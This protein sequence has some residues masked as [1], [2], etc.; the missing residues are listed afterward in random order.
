MIMK[1]KK[2]IVSVLIGMLAGQIFA[3]GDRPFTIINTLRVGYDDN[4]YRTTNDQE[5]SAYIRDIIDL[6]FRAALSDRTDLTFQSRFDYNSDKEQN[7]YPNLY[8]ILTHSAS[9]RLLLKLSNKFES[10]STTS[11]TR[12]GKYNY[13]INTLSFVPSYVLDSKNSLSTPVSYAIKRHEQIAEQLDYDTVSAGVTWKR[14]LVPQQTWAALSLSQKMIDYIN[15][16]SK[17]E[18][19]FASATVSHTFNPTLQG[20][21]GAG[22]TYNQSDFSIQLPGGSSRTITSDGVNPYFIAGL[23]YSPS[24]DTRFTADVT[25]QYQESD[26]QL[27]AGKNT[28]SLSLG[29][30][31]DFT[32]RIMG[33]AT[34]SYARSDYDNQDNEVVN[35]NDLSEDY[36]QLGVRVNY[37][38]NRNNFIELGLTRREKMYDNGNLDWDQNRVDIGWRVTL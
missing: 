36:V 38:V 17:N 23:V 19:T 8:A 27:Y 31:H 6:S 22:V 4:V 35:K 5:K 14:Q 29:F 32:A 9:P 25:Q 30:Q 1:N 34:A 26:S 37:K 16:D 2:L 10:N 33:K 7:F 18:I 11:A 12:S 21:L 20:K 15:R 3:E 28:Q 24:P 13:L